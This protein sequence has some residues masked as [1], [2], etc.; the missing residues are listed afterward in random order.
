MNNKITHTQ[1][2]ISLLTSR[3][4]QKSHMVA[5]SDNFPET[6]EKEVCG[7]SENNSIKVYGYLIIKRK[8]HKTKKIL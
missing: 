8:L 3:K 6:G 7:F 5:T 1:T 2:T 4:K